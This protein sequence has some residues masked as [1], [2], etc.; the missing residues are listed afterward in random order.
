LADLPAVA[1][2]A[3]VGKISPESFQD[4]AQPIF[5]P[6]IPWISASQSQLRRACRAVAAALWAE[7]SD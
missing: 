3:K 6:S 7:K 5:P 1:M 4:S 2:A